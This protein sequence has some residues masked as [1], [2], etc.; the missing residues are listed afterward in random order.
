MGKKK[1][2]RSTTNTS[3]SNNTD[4]MYH[5]IQTFTNN[6]FGSVRVVEEDDMPMFCA[7][8][9]ADALGYADTKNA[10]KLHCKGVA[11]YHPLQTAGGIQQTRFITEGDMYRLIASSKLESA[12]RFESWIFD[13]VVPSIRKH[14][15]YMA[16]QEQMT[17]EEMALASMQWLQSKVEEQQ[18]TI[19]KM[20]PKAQLA[21]SCMLST[22][23]IGIGDLAKI[24]E[25]VPDSRWRGGQNKLHERLRADGYT[26]RNH[27]GDI[28]PTQYAVDRGILKIRQSKR[29]SSDGGTHTDLTTKVT[30]KG[31]LYFIKKYC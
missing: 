19:E 4:S 28:I 20:K 8:D 18:N 23:V 30:Y 21:E 1:A 29:P 10:I 17:P 7:K 12:Q 24:M 31:Q 6:D 26:M 9:V 25:K 2:G 13:E 11:N 15:G 14:G 3:T 27:K 22:D 16:G 5:G